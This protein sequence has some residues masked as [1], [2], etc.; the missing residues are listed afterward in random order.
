MMPDSGC[1]QD[2]E[3]LEDLN[4]TQGSDNT[5]FYTGLEAFVDF[6]RFSN[7]NAYHALPSDWCVVLTDVC[8]STYAI[9]QG[10]YKQVNAVGVASIVALINAVK[11]F[12][13]PY[14]FGGDG[15]IACF[16]ESLMQ[17]VRS[18]LLASRAMAREQFDLELRI[19]IVPVHDIRQAGHDVRVARYQPHPSYQ[20]AM[21]SG[22][23]IAYAEDMIKQADGDHGYLIGEESAVTDNDFFAGFECRW[24]EVPGP[25]GEDVALLVRCVGIARQQ[26]E[27]IYAEI[28]SHIADIYGSEAQYHPLRESALSLSKKPALLAVE[29]GVRAAFKAPLYRRIYRASLQLR[30]RLGN[31]LMR[32]RVRRAGADWGLYRRHLIANTDY[33]KFDDMLR[34]LISGNAAQSIRLRAF[35]QDYRDRGL[36]VFGMHISTS[37]L[38]TCIVTDYDQQH[39]HFL[40][41]SNG[42]YAMASQQ[43]KQQIREDSSRK[44][45]DDG[46]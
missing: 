18:A 44:E 5:A 19:G 46:K 27:S 40:D 45:A 43:M 15:A 9:E 14:A 32:H 20:Q 36:I 13:L 11:P 12:T 4:R 7:P 25:H 2:T 17:P 42:G 24:N 31:W 33:R 21:F 38:I 29:A 3:H 16:P 8:N 10:R 23:G 39:V 30:R 1:L 26:Q 35:L 28:L 22:D 34:M 6:A 37:A 41:G